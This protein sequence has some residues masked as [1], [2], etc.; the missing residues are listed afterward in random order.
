MQ[1][2]NGPCGQFPL[3]SSTGLIF[4][5]LADSSP[6]RPQSED[7]TAENLGALEQVKQGH[8]DSRVYEGVSGLVGY[9]LEAVL[10]GG[11]GG[12][13]TGLVVVFSSSF[14]KAGLRKLIS[15][16]KPESL[17]PHLV[18]LSEI[19]LPFKT[20][21]L[22]MFKTLVFLCLSPQFC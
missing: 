11:G 17:L 4:P 18:P 21:L 10:T 14:T 6:S 1:R 3:L 9:C 7:P 5:G 16:L 22:C 12:S 13:N 2:K 15:K 20:F 19:F 8:Q